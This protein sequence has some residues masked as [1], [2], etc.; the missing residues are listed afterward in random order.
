MCLFFGLW[1]EEKGR[2]KERER[3]ILSVSSFFL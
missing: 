3:K 2:E 1:R